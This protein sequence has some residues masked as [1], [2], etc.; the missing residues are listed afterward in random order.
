MSTDRKHACSNDYNEHNRTF[1]IFI[2]GKL[3]HDPTAIVLILMAIFS[4]DP[5][6]YHVHAAFG[7]LVIDCRILHKPRPRSRVRTQCGQN[8]GSGETDPN[9]GRVAATPTVKRFEAGAG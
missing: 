4:F 1:E 5:A 7:W 6:A 2:P 8:S 9:E 3:G